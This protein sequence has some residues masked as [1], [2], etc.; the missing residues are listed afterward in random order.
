MVVLHTVFSLA[1]C[2][3]I[4]L[5]ACDFWETG[6]ARTGHPRVV[7]ICMLHVPCVFYITPVWEFWD[8][9]LFCPSLHFQ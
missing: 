3:C 7:L 4:A 8:V 6:L 2:V 1:V 5:C 9:A